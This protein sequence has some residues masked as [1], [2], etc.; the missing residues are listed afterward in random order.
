M[1]MSPDAGGIFDTLLGL[2]RRG[3]GGTAADG[4][5]Y[6]SWIHHRDFVRAVR[7]LIEHDDVAGAVNLAAPGPL[8]NAEF[9]RVLREAW[10]AR[11][12]LPATR[13]MLEIGAWLM[14]T[15]TELVL[16]SRRVVPGRR[17]RRAHLRLP[18]GPRPRAPC[19]RAIA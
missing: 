7:W 3:L 1:I 5:Q 15:E 8:P 14:R 2:V 16:K 4:R 6:I 9:M 19:R 18:P 12:G 17:C 13:W 10:G 11:L